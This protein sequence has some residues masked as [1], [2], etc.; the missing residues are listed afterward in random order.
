MRWKGHGLREW[1]SRERQEDVNQEPGEEDDEPDQRKQRELGRRAAWRK[2]RPCHE[3][4]LGER[5]ESKQGR[6]LSR[7]PRTHNDEHS[8][9]QRMKREEAQRADHE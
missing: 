5:Q 2:K 9:K 4:E 3:C 8:R 1:S 7:W 6:D